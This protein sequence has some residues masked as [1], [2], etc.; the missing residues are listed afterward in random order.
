MVQWTDKGFGRI[1][2]KIILNI[3]FP[4]MVS[5]IKAILVLQEYSELSNKEME[6]R[7]KIWNSNKKFVARYRFGDII[8]ESEAILQAIEKGRC[9]A[10]SEFNVLIEGD[11]GT[12]KEMF[13]QSIHNFSNREKAP[14]VGINIAGLPENLLESELFGYED[15]AFTGA[16]KGGKPGLF[17]IAHSGTIFI[18][19]IGDASPAVQTKIL[20]AIEEK[21]VMRLG[22]SNIHPVDVRIICATNVELEQLV[23]EKKF[24][25]DLFYRIKVLP[26]TLPNLNVRG[27]DV[28]LLAKHMAN[29]Y[30]LELDIDRRMSELLMTYNW[31]GNIRELENSIERACVLGHPP[32]IQAA[33]LHLTTSVQHSDIESLYGNAVA[34]CEQAEDKTLRTAVHNFKRAYVKR[35]LEENGGNQ[36]V[37]GRVLGIQRTYLSR[38][39]NELHIR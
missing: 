36:T 38:L 8:G 1:S 3:E 32:L 19:E 35:I 17:E 9:Y 22:G 2:G 18:D 15:G 10:Q 30:K 29:E 7:R 25:Q 23:K 21:E 5:D 39:L 26:L 13:A 14:F 24:R 6:S 28:I 11:S 20:R 37:T 12:G 4:R 16:A 31:P 33:D 27:K 34:E